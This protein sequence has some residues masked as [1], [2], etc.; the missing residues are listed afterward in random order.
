VSGAAK[1]WSLT[2]PAFDAFLASLD[3]DRPRAAAKYEQIRGKLIGFF[4]W[5]GMPFPEEHAD[6]TIDRIVRKIGEGDQIRDPST[7]VYGIARM[8]VLEIGRQRDRFVPIPDAGNLPGQTRTAEQDDSDERLPCLDLC[9]QKLTPQSRELI[10]EYYRKE[11][12]DKI[13]HRRRLAERIGIPVN[14]L[15]IRALRTRA[16]LGDC[17]EGCTKKAG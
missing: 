17:I 12:G 2:Q 10:T 3:E 7:Y 15:R 9:L 13:E 11:K 4:E 6:E 8:L 1:T 16:K 5:R 14:A